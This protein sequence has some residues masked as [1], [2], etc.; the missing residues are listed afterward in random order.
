MEK[1]PQR[2]M[3]DAKEEPMSKHIL[4]LAAFWVADIPA[5]TIVPPRL[6]YLL[7]ADTGKLPLADWA[8]DVDVDQ[9]CAV[10]V[11][12][13]LGENITHKV[14]GVRG[15]PNRGLTLDVLALVSKPKREFVPR[16]YS[17]VDFFQPEAR[18]SQQDRDALT[19]GYEILRENLERGDGRYALELIDREEFTFS[20]LRRAYEA[21]LNQTLDRSN[22]RKRVDRM[23]DADTVREIPGRMR[24]TLT[25]PASL[26]RYVG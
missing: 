5:S 25:R 20:E 11:R 13:I 2:V 4:R 6:Q 22:F 3:T 9:V 12:Q 21:V 24:K 14:V 26:Y 19:A 17:W 8:S 7:G 10:G 1:S 18:L 23:V 15:A 16:P